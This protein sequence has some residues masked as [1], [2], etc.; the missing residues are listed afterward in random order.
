MNIQLLSVAEYEYR[1]SAASVE[2]RVMMT[3]LI[4]KPN[5][6]KYEPVT[7]FLLLHE[8]AFE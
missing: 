3:F 8:T 2:S 1:E 4:T 7:C 6:T 5:I